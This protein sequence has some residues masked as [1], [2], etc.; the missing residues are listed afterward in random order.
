MN[1]INLA[2]TQMACSWDRQE[3]IDNAI[4]MVREAAAAGANIVLLQELFETPY[5][6]KDINE[7][8][9]ELATKVSE[10]P[11]VLQMQP[12]AKELGVVI[13]VS[14]FERANNAF[15]NT[16]VMIDADGEILGRYRK[17]HIPDSFGYTEKYYFSPGDTGIIV[18]NTR[19]CR[20]SVPVCWDQWFP[21]TARIATLRGAEL[22]LYPTAI[23]S[24]P[25]STDTAALRHWQRTQQGH[26]A[27]NVIPIAAANRI[28][29]EQGE[30]CD[31]RFFGS[32][33]ITDHRGEIVVEA[34]E[35]KR[36]VL[37]SE[38]D[39][40]EASRYR[41]LWNLFRDRRPDLYGPLMTL[42]G[43]SNHR[44]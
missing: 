2:I 13:P 24:E 33:F 41:N 36:Q 37:V 18:W 10:N 9:F 21:E 20:L 28:G 27:A 42:D 29:S 6:C 25:N 4:D 7:K 3:N 11:A 31:M 12:I 44:Y 26:A 43:E 34:S 32:S 19:F 16:L 40:G 35:D 23:G 38:I 5:F 17:S 22:I 30:S 15:F 14:I 39:L 8:Y 1:K